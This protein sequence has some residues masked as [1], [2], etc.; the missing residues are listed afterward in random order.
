MTFAS[1][2][3]HETRREERR[4]KEERREDENRGERRKQSVRMQRITPTT[5]DD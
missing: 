3:D 1:L 5:G 2:E 4:E